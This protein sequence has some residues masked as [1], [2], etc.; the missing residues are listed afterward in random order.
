MQNVLDLAEQLQGGQATQ[1][2]NMDKVEAFVSTYP[3][4]FPVLE[5]SIPQIKRFFPNAQL[6]IEVVGDPELLDDVH[7]YV[8]ISPDLAPTS[9]YNKLK[10]FR[11]AWGH[12][13]VDQARGKI[14]FTV[15]Y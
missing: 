14:A 3:Y 4:V 1:P 2:P 10:D 6:S 13:A 5:A 9:A 7:L 11:H 8:Y 15:R 12:Q